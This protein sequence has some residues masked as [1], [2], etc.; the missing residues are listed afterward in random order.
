MEDGLCVCAVHLKHAAPTHTARGSNAPSIIYVLLQMASLADCAAALFLLDRACDG[1]VV[2]LS[3][4]RGACPVYVHQTLFKQPASYPP[5]T[6]QRSSSWR[7]YFLA[8][9]LAWRVESCCVGDDGE[10]ESEDDDSSRSM[11]S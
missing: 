10:D 1:A 6:P 9:M 5:S 2:A 3:A 4:W 11:Y 8:G 7:R